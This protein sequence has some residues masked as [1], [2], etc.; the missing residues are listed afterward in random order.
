M[1]WLPSLILRLRPHQQ[2]LQTLIKEASHSYPNSLSALD[3]WK[4]PWQ[5]EIPAPSERQEKGKH[6][7][8]PQLSQT[9]LTIR[10]LLFTMPATTN[11]LAPL[12]SPPN[13]GGR[14]QELAWQ[15]ELA[16][17]EEASSDNGSKPIT[18][19]EKQI[20]RLLQTMPAT[21][22]AMGRLLG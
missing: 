12:L 17:T 7:T 5:K 14:I 2:I 19:T 18:E 15:E 20:Q 6:K 16:E 22:E 13:V 21:M 1:P 10:S 9:E 4:F 11:A 3:E 8:F